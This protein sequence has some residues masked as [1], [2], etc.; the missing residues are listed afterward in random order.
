V[1]DRTGIR[2]RLRQ[3]LSGSGD[4]LLFGETWTPWSELARTADTLSRALQNL[5]PALVAAHVTRNRPASAAALLALLRDGRCL[6][7]FS[8]IQPARTLAEEIRRAKPALIIAERDDWS[9][10]L[11]DAAD[12]LGALGLCI[13]PGRAD[14]VRPAGD[15]AASH[16][17]A[18]DEIALFMP[19]SG[20]T[21][22]PK[23]IPVTRAQLETYRAD[24]RGGAASENAN[25][26]VV[27]IAAPLFTV[28]G[29]RPF[30][31][32]ATRPL[33]LV[34][35]ERVDVKAWAA[36]VAKYRP[37]DGGLPP[38]AMRMLLESDVPRDSL[39]SLE[40]W[41]TGSAPVDPDVAARFEAEFG[42]PV[43]VAYGATEFGGA[44]TRM[45]LEDR[46]I[47]GEC[48]RASSGRAIP[49]N[50]LRIVNPL[51]GAV[52]P[53]GE[54]GLLEVRAARTGGHWLRTNDLARLDEDGFLFIEGRADDV[55][56]R[57]GFKVA[58]GEVEAVLET[59]PGIKQAAVLSEPDARLGEVPVAAVVLRESHAGLA[60]ADLEAWAREHLAPYKRPTQFIALDALPMTA[61]M[62]VNRPELRRQMA[63][64][65]VP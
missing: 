48:K 61:S 41:H 29:L 43:L 30:L 6:A 18:P 54:T 40:A 28:T 39:A 51:D 22:P 63:Q 24:R 5:D 7:Q 31:A 34:L 50:E 11:R 9:S 38:A 42:V 25:P 3:V 64:K 20:T 62:K 35:M 60:M 19:T 21:G 36:L 59:H 53:A 55:I 23:R 52:L 33:R 47:W 32:W 10:E 56:I 44:V 8:P 46:E 13:A 26:R 1:N 2:D 4:A 27:I 65:R 57:G 49:G 45:T 15:G 17:R 16:F 12:E 58:L 14:L 37:R